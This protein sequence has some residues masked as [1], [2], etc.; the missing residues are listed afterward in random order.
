MPNYVGPDWISRSFIVIAIAAAGRGSPAGA[1]ATTS[2]RAFPAD[3]VVLR[4][5]KRRVETRRVAGIVVGLL[6]PD[7]RRRIIAYG[8]PGPGQPPLDGNS[9][10]EI[11]S[12]TKVFTGMLLAQMTLTGEVSL[13]DPARKL[14]PATVRV[15]ERNGREITLRLLSTHRS[16]LPRDATNQV[17]FY[18]D[19]GVPQM[20]EFLSSYRLPREPG[21]EF[22][23]SNI[24][25]A[26]LGHALSRAGG[27]S[28]DELQRD[29]IWTPL[30]LTATSAALTPWQQ[31]HLALGHSPA[32]DVVP[33]QSQP[34]PLLAP[35]GG[36]RSTA[37]D[38]LTFLAAHVQPSATPLA[39]A[40]ELATRP[41]FVNAPGD[42]V[43]LNWFMNYAS[44]DT[45][46]WH[47]G[48][49]TGY[50]TWAGFVRSRRMAVVVLANS[51]GA[52]MDD[53]GRHLLDAK[54]ALASPPASSRPNV[55]AWLVG[56]VAL[57]AAL[58]GT[59][60]WR[61]WWLRSRGAHP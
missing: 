1:Q 22:E 7:G 54:F 4:I 9:V 34:H 42:A 36:I 45:I 24:G 2:P 49:T 5:I 16:G 60:R 26:V 52:S 35:V 44:G 41:Q 38:M 32:G 27:K 47:N 10:F 56:I 18:A 21:A 12:I 20:Y 39:A 51:R 29:R 17:N 25:V 15:P 30:G 55:V 58:Y 57:G 3:S 59:V 48:G 11:G 28:W 37:N 8:E 23:Y 46:V 43:G 19:Y 33:R 6:E 50:R 31:A 13:D 14:L 40:I 61:R 53:V